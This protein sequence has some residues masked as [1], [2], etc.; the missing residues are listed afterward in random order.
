MIGRAVKDQNQI[1]IG[2]V[3]KRDQKGAESLLREV[4]QLDTV[5]EQPRPRNRAKSFDSFLATEGFVFRRLPDTAPR[6]T[7]SA[8]RGQSHLIF[9]EDS[10]VLSDGATLALARGFGLPAILLGGIRQGQQSLWLLNTEASR[11]KQ[12]GYVVR[13]ITDAEMRSDERC[14]PPCIPQVV[15]KAGGRRPSI[16]QIIQQQQFFFAQFRGAS[17]SRAGQQTVV[18]LLLEVGNPIGDSA[19][20]DTQT[21]CDF[22]VRILPRDHHQAANSKYN[23][24]TS[25]TFR[26]SRKFL[27]IAK[28]ARTQVQF[29]ARAPHKY[30]P[31][32]R[33]YRMVEFA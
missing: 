33:G 29:F 31:S 23:I 24:A 20:G 21:G 19:A 13:M 12:L 25:E 11:S 26:L 28:M 18:S 16:H 1:A 17:R 30:P 7:D 15:G 27:Q 6:S 2:R 9:K 8:L 4:A 14:H 3:T 10:R 32:S 5:A 22:S